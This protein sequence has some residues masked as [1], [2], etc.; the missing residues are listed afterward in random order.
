VAAPLAGISSKATAALLAELTERYRSL[1]SI[2]V[3]FESVGGV[4]A[5]RRVREG[6]PFDVVVL[7]AAA[8]DALVSDG[9]VL[10]EG[11]KDIVRSRVVAAVRAGGP[12]PAIDSVERLQ[13]ALLAAA[14][15]GFS[16]GPSGSALKKLIAAWGLQA[17]LEP[18]LRQAP[19]GVPVG[20]LIA[21]GDVDIGFQQFSEL[22]G[23]PGIA[24][25]D[26]LPPGAAIVST[27]SAGVCAKAQDR[28]AALRFVDFL[29]SA[30]VLDDKRRHGFEP[31]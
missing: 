5:A 27:F 22:M 2:P 20:S 11:R 28:D 7:D 13:S 25:L 18:K 17:E 23:V 6:E 24:I 4:D 8:I 14:S 15:I 9:C 26:P 29:A 30:G 3:R 21:K 31:A 12:A 10:A 19:P 1:H 16:T